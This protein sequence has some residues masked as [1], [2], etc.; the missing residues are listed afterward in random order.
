[1][2]LGIFARTFRR[3][4]L[5]VMLDAVAAHGLRCV[6]LNL[7]EAGLPPMPDGFAPADADRIRAAADA[8]GIRIAAVSGTFN[9]IHPDPVE[10]ARGI[11]RLGVLASVCGR[12]GTSV[13]TLCTGTRDPDDIWRRHP[14]NDTPAAWRDLVA[15]MEA[16]LTVTEAQGVKLAFEPE[17]GN[18][19]RT[20]RQALDLIRELGSP[21]LGVVLDPA[22]LF[23]EDKA[24]RL[25]AILD[26]AVDL[27]G[28]RVFLAHAKDR[29][30][31]W[32]VRPA[33]KGIV[34]WDRFFALL[35][36]AGYDGAVVLHGLDEAEVGPAV[37]FLRDQ[38]AGLR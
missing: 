35:R 24:E 3:P 22:N 11:A 29:G 26:E 36:A 33:G 5:A 34:P 6:Q 14:E 7:E 30:A 38:A 32:T 23:A 4:S 16:A 25:P 27:L 17:P 10:R 19:V 28:E 20:A 37:A 31:D 8:R 13:I 21:R 15:A 18:V 1:M 12:L 9:M 2:E